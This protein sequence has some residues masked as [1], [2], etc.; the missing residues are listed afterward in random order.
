MAVEVS[1]GTPLAT[2]LQNVVQPRL[3]EAGWTTGGLDDSALS[4]Y[5]IL[6]LANGKTQE[7]IASELSNDLLG[8]GPEDDGAVN[9]SQWLF[10]QVDI[11]SKQLNGSDQA[12]V[13]SAGESGPSSNQNNQ[14]EGANGNGLSSNYDAEMGDTAE[15]A[16]GA[17]PTGPKAM[18]NGSATHKPRDKRMLGQLNKAMDRSDD[19]ALHRVRGTTGTG[20]INSHSGR[21]PPRGPRSQLNRGIAAVANGRGMGAMGTMGGMNG[22][23]VSQIGPNGPMNP[24]MSPQQQ[25]ALLQMYEQQAQLMQQLFSGPTPMPFINPNFQGTNQAQSGKSLFDRV[26]H[27][28]QRQNDRRHPQHSNKFTKKEQQDDAMMDSVEPDANGVPSSSMDVE[29]SQSRSPLDPSQTICKF[30]LSCTKAECPFAHQSPAAPP[31]TSVDMSDTCPFAA[32]CMN[33]KCVGKHPSPAQ[34]QSHKAE[35]DCIFYPNCRDQQNCP[36]K[37]PSMPP[38]RNGADCTVPNCKF[39]HSKVMCKFNPCKNAYCPF[40]HADG[41]K[42]GSFED[43]VWTPNDEKKEHVSERKFVDEDGEEELILPG[44]SSQE[45]ETQIIT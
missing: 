22:M 41:Q 17:I 10:Q 7:Q 33:K 1:V 30:N 32:A 25:M 35:Q 9:F 43:K 39:A 40:K 20:R 27:Q 26:D 24:L 12:G 11:L 4:E 36:F 19:S 29:V 8:L 34:R 6:M 14:S 2:A 21:E 28:S 31:G 18:R 37:H 16:A 23:P 44:R 3:A 38:C 5:I 13:F 42:R 45:V 15:A